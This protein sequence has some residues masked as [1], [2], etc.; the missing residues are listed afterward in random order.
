MYCNE[1]VIAFVWI[2]LSKNL[3]TALI[4]QHCFGVPVKIAVVSSGMTARAAAVTN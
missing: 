1:N 3:A 2:V 4:L